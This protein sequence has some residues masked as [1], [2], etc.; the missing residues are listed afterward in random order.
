MNCGTTWAKSGD[1]LL[2]IRNTRPNCAKLNSSNSVSNGAL[3]AAECHKG[4]PPPAMPPSNL[5]KATMSTEYLQL[6]LSS[7]CYGK[8]HYRCT[9]TK[10]SCNCMC[11]RG[12]LPI[13]RNT[14]P[15]TSHIAAREIA[16]KLPT[17]IDQ[18]V[19][20]VQQHPGKTAGWYGEHSQINGC[21]KR[22]SDAKN[23]GRIVPGVAVLYKGKK[24]LTWWPAE[25]GEK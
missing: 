8:I 19:E 6:G 14:D 2:E 16:G 10:Q 13:A 4:C 7:A 18:V 15:D 3:S 1:K 20:W 11:H 9:S 24:Q 22:I 5:A 17:L 25:Q 21:W 12:G 23:R